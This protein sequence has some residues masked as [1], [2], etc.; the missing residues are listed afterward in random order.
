[1]HASPCEGVEGFGSSLEGNLVGDE[2]GAVVGKLVGNDVGALVGR[3]VSKG[4]GKEVETGT[5]FAK[6]GSP[7]SPS[8]VQSVLAQLLQLVLLTQLEAVQGFRQL[9]MR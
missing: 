2:V 6:L 3:N 8:F 7:S 9:P 4:V 5:H 1:M